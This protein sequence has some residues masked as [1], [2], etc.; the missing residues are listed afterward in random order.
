[1]LAALNPV[2]CKAFLVRRLGVAR[3]FE[4]PSAT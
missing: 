4:D 2:S 3:G 1:M